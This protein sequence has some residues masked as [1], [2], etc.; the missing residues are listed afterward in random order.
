MSLQKKILAIIPA[1]AGS[2]GLP[3]KNIRSLNGVP[4]IGWSINTANESK[5]ISDCVVS[6]D[7]EKIAAIA[8]DLGG[9]VVMRPAILAT[10]TSLPKDAVLHVLDTLAAQG[11]QYEYVVLLQPTSP[12]R[13]AS[14]IDDCIELVVKQSLDSA[15]SFMKSMTNPYRAFKIEEGQ[16]CTFIDGVNPWVPRQQLPDSYELNGAVYVVNVAAFRRD[17]SAAFV[18]GNSG[19]TIMPEERSHDIDTLLDFITCEA[20]M[21]L[22][23]SS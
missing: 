12:L 3:G 6:T 16:M 2:K 19:A 7:G 9:E 1:R 21:K 23:K 11:R 4:L 15:A 20:M 10:D 22:N 8:E 17:T 5:H 13:F 18:F 14:D